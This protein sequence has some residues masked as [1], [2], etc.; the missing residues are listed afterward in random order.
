VTAGLVVGCLRDG[1]PA[2]IDVIGPGGEAYGHLDGQGV[3]VVA[4]NGAKPSSERDKSGRL[5]F[6]N[7]RA[8]WYWRMREALD[9]AAAHPLALPPHAGL[10]ADLCAARWK[11]TPRGIQVEAKDEIIKR[12]GRSPD[13]ADAAVYAL[14]DAPGRDRKRARGPTQANSK[15]SPHTW[16]R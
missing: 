2:C 13:F 14:I 9:P 16:R 5:P 7:K 6:V 12:L 10:R 1:A 4:M 15:Y 3:N 8:E 11:L